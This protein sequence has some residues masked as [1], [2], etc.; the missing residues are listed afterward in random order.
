MAFKDIL[1]FVTDK[2]QDVNVD[3]VRQKLEGSIPDGKYFEHWRKCEDLI[4]I[5]KS[6]IFLVKS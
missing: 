5:L 4:S 3:G 2:L 6:R 1:H